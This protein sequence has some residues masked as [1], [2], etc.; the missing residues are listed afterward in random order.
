LTIQDSFYLSHLYRLFVGMMSK[1]SFLLYLVV[2]VLVR[3]QTAT[4]GARTETYCS[5]PTGY[6]I[7][8]QDGGATCLCVSGNLSACPIP[9]ATPTTT[10]T[11]VANPCAP[12]AGTTQTAL[13]TCLMTAL[14]G[15]F[16]FGYCRDANLPYASYPLVPV[17]LAGCTAFNQTCGAV[18]TNSACY[19]SPSYTIVATTCTSNA[20][21]IPSGYSTGPIVTVSQTQATAYCQTNFPTICTAASPPPPGTPPSSSSAIIARFSLFGVA[22]AALF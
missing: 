8:A 17:I 10:P 7:L 12:A 15:L 18:F 6:T 2:I 22:F 19:L 5:Y 16:N 20:S 4:L 14:P 13:V 1:I 9:T 21:L 3:A 11:P